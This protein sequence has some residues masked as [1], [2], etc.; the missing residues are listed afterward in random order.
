MD[1]S[2]R[3]REEYSRGIGRRLFRGLEVRIAFIEAVLLVEKS[4]Q[5]EQTPNLVRRQI[6]GTPQLRFGIAELVFLLCDPRPRKV[7]FRRV[8]LSYGGK[9]RFG[10]IDAA[11]H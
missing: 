11:T 8:V 1:V 3:A 10:A 9:Q 2:G 4:R 6:H 5:I 7:D